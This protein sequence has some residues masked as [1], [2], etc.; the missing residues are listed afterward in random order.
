MCFPKT[1]SLF[2]PNK[3]L[4]SGF[5]FPACI[6]YYTAIAK[7]WLSTSVIT[8]VFIIWHSSVKNSSSFFFFS[9]SPWS[10]KFF[11]SMWYN[12]LLPI[13][14]LMLKLPQICPIGVLSEG[15]CI[16]L[17]WSYQPLSTYLLSYTRYSRLNLYFP[18][19]RSVISHFFKGNLLFLVINN[20]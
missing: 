10:Q 14:F 4:P 7:W 18:C 6:C 3:V 9:L 1:F 17:I 13:F 12:L 16:L 11:S 2:A 19:W 8:S 20:I 5:G 15:F